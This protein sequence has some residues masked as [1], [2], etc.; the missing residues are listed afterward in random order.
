MAKKSLF[1]L[2]AKI[3]FAAGSTSF[4]IRSPRYILTAPFHKNGLLK[5]IR[6]S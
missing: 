1:R 6:R 3:G 5:P 4:C 2:T